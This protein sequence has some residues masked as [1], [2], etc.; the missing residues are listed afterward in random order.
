MTPAHQNLLTEIKLEIN[1][2]PPQDVQK[3]A[4]LKKM[5]R[6]LEE[7][8]QRAATPPVMGFY[9]GVP[10]SMRRAEQKEADQAKLEGR[11]PAFWPEGITRHGQG[12]SRWIEFPT[13]M[14]DDIEWFLGHHGCCWQPSDV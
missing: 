13:E 8:I 2:T 10:E 7:R 12:A 4:S 9:V 1:R 3:L 5:Q 11:S 14:A 6:Q